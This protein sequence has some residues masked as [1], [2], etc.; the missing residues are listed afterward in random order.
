[1]SMA[2]VL[3]SPIQAFLTLN[4]TS[5]RSPASETPVT[6][7]TVTPATRTGLPGCRPAASV[8]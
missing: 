4:E 1:M 6:R 5:T 2:T 7:P 8:K 3:A